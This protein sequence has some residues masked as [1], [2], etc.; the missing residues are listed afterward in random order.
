M[1]KSKSGVKI[2]TGFAFRSLSRQSLKKYLK[3]CSLNAIL[4]WI[5]SNTMDFIR[6]SWDA[7]SSSSPLASSAFWLTNRS[8]VAIFSRFRSSPVGIVA[9][10]LLNPS[11]IR[12]ER[13]VGKKAF[14]AGATNTNETF[15]GGSSRI[16][17]RAFCDSTRQNLANIMITFGARSLM[18][19]SA[20]ISFTP[21][22]RSVSYSKN[23]IKS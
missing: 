21:S 14:L 11:M 15:L 9:T 20:M 1:I 17:N 19:A 5:A 10:E 2:C 23:R 7:R 6:A 4:A 13:I 18:I 16:F 3:S 12:R 22:K 8:I